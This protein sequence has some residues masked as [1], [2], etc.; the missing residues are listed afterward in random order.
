MKKNVLALS[1][2]AMIGGLGL[3][4]VA[5]AAVIPGTGTGG[6]TLTDATD[7]KVT[8]GGVGHILLVPYFTAQNGNATAIHLVNTDTTNGKAV[9][10][11]FRGAA[12]SDD[13]LDF[14]LLLSPGDVWTG[15]VTQGA[16]GVAQLTTADKSCTFPSIKDAGGTIPFVKDRLG[17]ALLPDVNS[18]TRE[19]YVEILNM[20]DIKPG[21][22]PLF[23]AI[24]HVNGTAPC[25]DS[26]LSPTLLVDPANEAA[27]AT[28]GFDTPSGGLM[29]DWY[30]VNVPQTTTFSGGATAV[31][32]VKTGDVNAHGNFVF[33]PQ[34]DT[35]A[36][37]IA[38]ADPLF[39]GA[40]PPIAAAM[41]DLPDLSTPYIVTGTP[42]L[43]VTPKDQASALA[44]A[45]SVSNVSNQYITDP[46]L[47]A[48]TDWVFS[49]PTRRYEV[50]M[51]YATNTRV[52][53]ALTPSRFN[54]GNTSVSGSLICVNSQG[55]TFYDQE[56]T[57]KSA[58]AVFSPGQVKVTRF[59]GETS[60]LS[61][62]A[63]VL[64]AQ[65]ATQT[66]TSAY[67]NGWGTI[68][69][70]NGGF[71]LPILGAAFIKAVNGAATPGVSGTYGISFS[72]RF[73]PYAAP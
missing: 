65:V 72:H 57:S 56:E 70:T 33:S 1:M 4:G 20:A 17:S 35:A 7:L 59:C 45:I 40:T 73:T 37:T 25:T 6:M 61:F 29:G 39:A 60:V 24:K 49:M 50:A 14:T 10:V 31:K 58:G 26:V 30:I 12:N 63:S 15:M 67:V 27:A 53:T 36:S 43:P 2:A 64:G 47:S 9:K 3:A 19:G 66:T 46:G 32:A 41:Y 69:T 38:S 42:S 62:G 11:R 21:N 16:D 55:Q 13:I 51:D 5:S 44:N 48:S 28:A 68:N 54:S 71:G 23:T 52:Y 8:Y 34:L 22:N 18:N